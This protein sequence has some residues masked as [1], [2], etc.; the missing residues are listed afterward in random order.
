MKIVVD[1]AY[2]TCW[3][4]NLHALPPEHA[5]LE[6]S[7][8]ARHLQKAFAATKAQLPEHCIDEAKLPDTLEEYTQEKRDGKAPHKLQRH[9][10]K[11]V[12][13]AMKI[14]H[15]VVVQVR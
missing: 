12:E 3:I 15:S 13:R 10:V 8:L 5:D 2:L 4:E 11:E 9:L 1:A 14:A 6:H 7:T